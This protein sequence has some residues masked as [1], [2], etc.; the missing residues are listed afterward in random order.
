MPSDAD[1]ILPSVNLFFGSKICWP[2]AIV[3]EDI[4]AGCLAMLSG[5]LNFGFGSG[6][7]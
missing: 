1:R 7:V 6:F 2:K 3:A 5:R 4:V